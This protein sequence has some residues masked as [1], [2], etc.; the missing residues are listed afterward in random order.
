MM[1]MLTDII[2]VTLRSF[3]GVDCNKRSAS[4]IEQLAREQRVMRGQI[5]AAMATDIVLPFKLH[6]LP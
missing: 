1:Q 6:L 2:A 4:V 5:L 3:V